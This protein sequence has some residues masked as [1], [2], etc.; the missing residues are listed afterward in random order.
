MVFVD[1]GYLIALAD[2]S[3]PHHERTMKTLRRTGDLSPNPRGTY[4]VGRRTRAR[5]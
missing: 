1:T 2:A 4:R 5:P 3:D